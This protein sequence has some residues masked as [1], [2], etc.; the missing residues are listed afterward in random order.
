MPTLQQVL[1]GKPP[2]NSK[3]VR[4]IQAP[5]TG[6]RYSGGG[7]VVV[8]QMIED[9]TGKPLAGLAQEL[10]FD[11]LGMTN[12]ENGKRLGREVMRAIPEVLGWS[13]Y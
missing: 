13:G 10:I 12:G 6:F 11:R 3:P 1:D 7:Y 5:G 9:V 4:V 8:Q 2:A